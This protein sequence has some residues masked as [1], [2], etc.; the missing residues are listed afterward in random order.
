MPPK[1]KAA[2]NHST[3]S[4]RKSSRRDTNTQSIPNESS[5]QSSR[6]YTEVEV[7][8]MIARAVQDG[9]EKA[10]RQFGQPSV[11]PQNELNSNNTNRTVNVSSQVDSS[12]APPVETAIDIISD[13]SV[14]VKVEYNYPTGKR[15]AQNLHGT[16]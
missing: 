1:R 13:A 14:L 15:T 16:Y 6:T 11:R 3:V 2:A 5:T 9:V 4:Q 10:C 7:E 8:A 12:M